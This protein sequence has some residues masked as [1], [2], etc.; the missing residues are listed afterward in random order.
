MTS[1]IDKLDNKPLISD[2]ELLSITWSTWLTAL[3]ASLVIFL[4]VRYDLTELK[5]EFANMT[6]IINDIYNIYS[7]LSLEAVPLIVID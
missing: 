4:I 7:S 1:S 3:I 6:A 2:G 5:A